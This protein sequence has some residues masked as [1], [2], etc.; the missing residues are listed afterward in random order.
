[1]NSIHDM[2]GMLCYG[3]IEYDGGSEAPFRH[4]W[5]RRTFGIHMLTQ[6]EGMMYPDECRHEMEKMHPVEYLDAPYYEHWLY[7]TENL[8]FAKGILTREEVAERI[9]ML[10]TEMKGEE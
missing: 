7:A 6:L 5:E 8:L 2:G 9:E 1:M 3:P 10:R 4:D